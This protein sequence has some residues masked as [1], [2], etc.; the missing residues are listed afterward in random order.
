[1]NHPYLGVGQGVIFVGPDKKPVN[2]KITLVYGP[3]SARLEWANGVAVA[4]YSDEQHPNTFHFE[5]ASHK[6]EHKKTEAKQ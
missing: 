6:A 5:Q 2:A 4:D 3:D 1:M